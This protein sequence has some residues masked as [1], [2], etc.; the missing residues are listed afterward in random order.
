MLIDIFFYIYFK[1]KED[2]E[3]LRSLVVPLEEEIDV[4]KKKLR[5]TD[6]QLQR[7]QAQ[8]SCGNNFRSIIFVSLVIFKQNKINYQVLFIVLVN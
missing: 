5:E 6:E 4:L 7:Y 8:V 1:A 2:A 3:M